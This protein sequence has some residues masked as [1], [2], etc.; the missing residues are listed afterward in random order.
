MQQKQSLYKIPNPIGPKITN[1][2][3]QPQSEDEFLL[4]FNLSPLFVQLIQ[5][6]LNPLLRNLLILSDPVDLLKRCLKTEPL[7]LFAPGLEGD[8]FSLLWNTA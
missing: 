3:S 5:F 8:L 2:L 1:G 6:L 4:T 7:G